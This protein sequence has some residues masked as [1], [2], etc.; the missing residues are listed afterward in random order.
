HTGYPVQGMLSVTVLTDSGVEG[1]A[2]DDVL[3]VLGVEKSKAY[4]E[5]HLGIE[6]FFYLPDGDKQWKMVNLKN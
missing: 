2:I 4:L 5:K 6:A 3:Y 1:D